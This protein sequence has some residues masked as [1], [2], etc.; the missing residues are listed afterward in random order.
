MEKKP[1]K[2]RRTGIQRFEGNVRDFDRKVKIPGALMI[3]QWEG[4]QMFWDYESLEHTL[5]LF[6]TYGSGRSTVLRIP[7]KGDEI[8]LLRGHRERGGWGYYELHVEE[9]DERA[10]VNVSFITAKGEPL[11]ILWI[12]DKKRRDAARRAINRFVGEKLFSD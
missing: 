7:L 6:V 3:A 10:A 12:I 4:L 11:S 1:A 9:G 2:A 5:V 8:A